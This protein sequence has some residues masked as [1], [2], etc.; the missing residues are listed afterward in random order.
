MADGSDG[1]PTGLSAAAA[2]GGERDDLA[3]LITLKE[4]RTRE[5]DMTRKRVH[6][7]LCKRMDTG[8]RVNKSLKAYLTRHE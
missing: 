8:I 5:E 2:R 4:Q 7:Q 3:E 1:R 6:E